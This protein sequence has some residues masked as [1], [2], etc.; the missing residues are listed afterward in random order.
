MLAASISPKATGTFGSTMPSGPTQLPTAAPSA[1]TVKSA[2]IRSIQ[3]PQAAKVPG[4][5]VAHSPP[6]GAPM[7]SYLMAG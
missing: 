2:C 7:Y 1:P 5:D 3:S 6:P 4:A